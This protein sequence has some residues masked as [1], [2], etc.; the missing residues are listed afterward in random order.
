MSY[1]MHGVSFQHQVCLE[2][3][4]HDLWSLGVCENDLCILLQNTRSDTWACECLGVSQNLEKT[5]ARNPHGHVHTRM[6]G[7]VTPLWATS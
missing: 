1:S 7:R 5:L 4:F 2:L 6:D 3:H